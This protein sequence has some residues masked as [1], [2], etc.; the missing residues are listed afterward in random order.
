ME[1]TRLRDP[2]ILDRP[3]ERL[4]EAR[5]PVDEGEALGIVGG[6]A[7]SHRLS[8][9]RGHRHQGRDGGGKRLGVFRL[10]EDSCLGFSD[11]VGGVSPDPHKNRLAR[12]EIRLGFRRHGDR[13]KGV[14]AEVDEEGVRRGDEGGHLV[15][16]SPGKELDVRNRLGAGGEPVAIHAAADES[17]AYVHVASMQ[18]RR[19]IEHRVECLGVAHRAREKDGERPIGRDLFGGAKCILVAPVRNDVDLLGVDATLDE[20]SFEARRKGGDPVHL[21]V[22]PI[23]VAGETLGES[24]GQ[25]SA[26][27]DSV[28]PKVLD[29]VHDGGLLEGRKPPR[30]KTDCRRGVVDVDDVGATGHEG[31]DKARAQREAEIV[32]DPPLSGGVM[33]R[34][35][36]D[37][38]HPDAVER[39]APEKGEAVAGID[40]STGIVGESGEDLDLVT[41]TDKLLGERDALENRLRGPELGKE[42]DTHLSEIVR[43]EEV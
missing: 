14:V 10:E 35:E 26:R 36:P 3:F 12:V 11:D 30:R 29:V 21:P 43:A 22:D 5:R 25:H 40:L 37:A 8:R 38:V 27:G 19:R 7:H 34:V 20:G 41:A 31:S 4:L 33:A 2:V 15:H 1:F 39:L 32:E 42:K 23:A 16:G 13:E 24:G 6:S 18:K 9:L 17:E 28:G